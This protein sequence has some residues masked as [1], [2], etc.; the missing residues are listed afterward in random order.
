MQELKYNIKEKGDCLAEIEI[1][2][3]WEKA[4]GEIEKIYREISSGLSLPGF[5]KGKVPLDMVKERFGEEAKQEMIRKI[6][7]RLLREVLEKEN[8]YPVITPEMIEYELKP[9][10]PFRLKF[11]IEKMS[12]ITPKK[13]K[14]MKLSKKIHKVGDSDVKKTLNNLKE[15]NPKLE[16][17]E[18]GAEIGD[19]AMVEFCVFLDSKKIDLGRENRRFLELGKENFLPGFDSNITGMKKGEEKEF[20]YKFPSDYSR[21]E[22]SGQEAVFKLILK[23]LKGK[24]LPKDKEIA[25][26]MGLKNP[27]ELKKHI[28]LSLKK[29]LDS[30]SEKEVENQILDQLLEKNDFKV[31]SGLVEERTGEMVKQMQGYIKQK[32][33]D[34]E[35]IDREKV[36]Q[37]AEKEI[38]A[39]VLLGEIAREEGIKLS[40]DDIEKRKKEIAGQIGTNDPSETEKYL[41]RDALLAQKVFTF[42]KGNA[43]ISEK[44]V[45]GEK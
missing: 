3:P 17:K 15:Q 40:D 12:E 9:S 24:L 19:Y 27:D 23:E 8:I 34:P 33:G 22:L 1:E 29:Q 26:A 25:E 32:G 13:Y 42:I 14:K 2:V 37:R 4:A 5:R 30:S 45:K 35:E 38:K 7:P 20:V 6:S 10:K 41:D 28:S 18:G 16:A 36:K 44:K 11:K 39:G 31:P 21:S 43:K